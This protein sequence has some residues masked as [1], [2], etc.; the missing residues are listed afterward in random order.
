VVW[1]RL[2]QRRSIVRCRKSR[3]RGTIQLVVDAVPGSGEFLVILASFAAAIV[4]ADRADEYSTV[5]FLS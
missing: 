5:F 4:M 2:S 1:T 3:V